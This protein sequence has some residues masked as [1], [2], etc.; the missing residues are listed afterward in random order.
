MQQKET[1]FIYRL[2]GDRERWAGGMRAVFAQWKR[3]LTERP[4]L[5]LKC[6]KTMT[7]STS[8]TTDDL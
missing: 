3:G 6:L 5:G 1:T 4:I 2:E 8:L 7:T